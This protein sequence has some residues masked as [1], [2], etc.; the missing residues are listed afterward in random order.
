MKLT[1]EQITEQ[2][3]LLKQNIE[4]GELTLG[5]AVRQMRGITGMN[6]KEYAQK[7]VGI[8]PRILAEIERDAGNPTLETLNKIGRPFGYRVGFVAKKPAG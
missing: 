1:R 3:Q 2:K 6:Q 5:Q 4:K 8:S 7:I